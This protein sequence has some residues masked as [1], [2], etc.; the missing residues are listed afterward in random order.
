MH[1]Y[2]YFDVDRMNTQFAT[3]T[4]GILHGIMDMHGRMAGS[5][6]SAASQTPGTSRSRLRPARGLGFD[7]GVGADINDYIRAGMSVTDIGSVEWTRNLE[8]VVAS[9]SVTVDNPMDEAQR[10]SL[11]NTFSGDRKPCDPFSSSLPTTF[12]VGAAVQLH[13]VPALKK[14]LWGEWMFACDYN[15]GLVEG[16][17]GSQTGRFSMGLEFKPWKFLPLRTGASFGGPDHFNFALGFGLHF[18]VFDLDLASDNLN[19]L[20][21]EASLAHGSVAMGMR[22]RI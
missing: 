8:Q 19:F 1:G 13:N 21:S 9:G 7:L 2:G 11:E 17:G 4:D 18:G 10:D 20:L 22:V 14:I 15:L 12:R 16:A 5:I 6:R 3:G